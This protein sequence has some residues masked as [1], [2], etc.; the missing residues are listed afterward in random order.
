MDFNKIFLSGRIT[1]DVEFYYTINNQAIL[2]LNIEVIDKKVH[3]FFNVVV[4]GE[5]AE[6]AKKKLKKDKKVFVEGR[7]RYSQYKTRS[8]A[9]RSKIEVIADKIFLV[10][11]GGFLNGKSKPTAN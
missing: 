3:N 4:F 6:F 11:E 8:G 1:R 9:L 7:L 5:L 2:K 10:D